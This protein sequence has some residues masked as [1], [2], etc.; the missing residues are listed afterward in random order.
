[1][2]WTSRE[3]RILAGLRTPAHIQ[4][5][6]DALDYDEKGGGDSPRVVMR[7]G[8]AQCFSGALFACAAL[9]ELGHPPRLMYI[10]AASDDGH[11]LA[12]Y[13]SGGLWG[14]IAKSN[15]T[16]LRSRELIYPYIALSLSSFEGF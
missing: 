7:M 12:L 9:R 2:R 1:M 10:H 6:L 3:R 5:F 4:Q 11:C 15:F 14:A 8:K 16:T 13:E